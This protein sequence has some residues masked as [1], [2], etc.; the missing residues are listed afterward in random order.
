MKRKQ[1]NGPFYHQN[2]KRPVSR[3]ELLGQ[4]F[5][6]ATSSVFLPSLSSML[7]SR[8]AFALECAGGGGG[9]AGTARNSVAFL[10]FDLA[11][12]G[13]IAGSNVV[14]GKAGGQEDFLTTYATLGLPDAMSPKT[15]APNKEFGLAFHPD[16]GMLRGMQSV[17]TDAAIKA[18][19]DGVV[20]C[21]SSNDDTANNPHN[22]A[23]WIAKAG[24]A[25]ELVTLV[26]NAGSVSG[27][28][29]I[30]PAASVNPAQRPVTI[31]SPDDVLGL[32]NPGKIA[33]LLGD[34][35]ALAK[36][37]AAARSMSASQLAKFEEKDMPAQLRDLVEC[38]YMG[39]GDLV[40]QYGPAALDPRQDPMVT[41]IFTNMTGTEAQVAS[42]TK[43]LLDGYA[44]AGTITIGGY[45]YHNG[46]RA[47][48][49]QKTFEA[50]VLIGKAIRLA[51]AKN[52]DLMIY[53]Y[54]DGGVVANGTVDN[55][56]NGRGKFGWAGDSGQRSA[57][58]ALVY[59]KD[60]KVEIRDNRRQI[61]AY[62]DTGSV[63]EALTKI[64]GSVENL[65]KAVVAN[66]LA[67]SGKEGSLAS[68]VGT[69]P[70]GA[71]LDQYLAFNKIR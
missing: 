56:T 11:G 54:T 13:N 64:S 62:K 18:K 59:K 6:A 49:E 60:G 10:I 4:G 43:L 69:D 35:K 9:G 14:V 22:P 44:G 23:Y 37:L 24:A 70:F 28:R 19:V 34:D 40:S 61:G 42:V 16:S 20:F 30:A 26:G 21:A 67:L 48:G 41:S 68:V 15:L 29:A 5:L 46:S 36:I 55:S 1:D 47:T 71:E 25:G 31:A 50:G 63:D 7:L 53:V 32:V 3:R 45:D 2:H 17:I 52:Q 39:S 58:Y 38:G 66:Y 57:S 8:E 12:G 27:G 65:T 33:T 51:A